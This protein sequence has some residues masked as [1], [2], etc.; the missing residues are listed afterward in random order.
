MMVMLSLLHLGC[1]ADVTSEDR[2]PPA[3]PSPIQQQVEGASVPSLE[4]AMPGLDES[5]RLLAASDLVSGFEV[6]MRAK[7]KKTRRQYLELE[8]RASELAIRE[9]YSGVDSAS[10]RR[11]AP[12]DYTVNIADKTGD[13]NI[14]H[15][16]DSLKRLRLDAKYERSHIAIRKLTHWLWQMRVYDVRRPDVL[17]SFVPNLAATGTF[18]K[19]RSPTNSVVTDAPRSAQGNNVPST[20]T[21]NTDASNGTADGGGS[22]GGQAGSKKAGTNAESSPS[23]PSQNSRD[24][25]FAEAWDSASARAAMAQ[26]AQD[27][28][29]SRV[30]GIPVQD[31]Q[32]TFQEHPKGRYGPYPPSATK[33][34]SAQVR[35]WQQA[36]P[37]KTFLD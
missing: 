21:S 12:R 26:R 28:P 8:L 5:G 3:V 31:G 1:E 7:L 14:A 13:I 2:L 16:R 20:Q 35:Q 37:D 19:T 29:P 32:M 22:R 11:F 36:N 30:G 10:G 25:G 33:N 23:Q 18:S 17:R 9:F 6:P 15:T 27:N 24:T 4:T 34:I